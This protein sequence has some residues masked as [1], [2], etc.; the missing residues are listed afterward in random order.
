QIAERARALIPSET[1]SDERKT[2]EGG[3]FHLLE[4]GGVLTGTTV[5]GEH[6]GFAFGPVA[7]GASAAGFGSAPG[8]AAN[9]RFA[10]A[11]GKVAVARPSIR[12]FADF[13]ALLELRA[14][15]DTALL[16]RALELTANA[17]YCA[18][19]G[20]EAD[21]YVSRA[22]LAVDERHGL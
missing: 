3:E 21:G 4:A 10:A 17:A 7:I 18:E 2:L 15:G 13:G 19:S 14:G 5:H 22:L 12:T 11:H 6:L 1:R 20:L 9:P 8:L 16:L